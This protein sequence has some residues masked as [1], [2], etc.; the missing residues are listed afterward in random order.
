MTRAN[1][2]V[3][4]APSP[5]PLLPSADQTTPFHLATWS[6]SGIPAVFL[7]SPPTYTSFPLTA[8]ALTLSAI[9]PFPAPLLPS[10]DQATPFHFATLSASGMPE[11][12]IKSPPTINCPLPFMARACTK[13]FIAPF[14]PPSLPSA[15]QADPSHLAT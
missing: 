12:S 1:T 15:D 10:A 4:I 14:P 6:A 8:I 5:A 3:P 2:L 11:T 7:K 9:A 13:F